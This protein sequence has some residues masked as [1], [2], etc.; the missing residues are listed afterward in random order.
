MSYV[1]RFGV[2]GLGW[3]A[4]VIRTSLLIASILHTWYFHEKTTPEMGFQRSAVWRA[5]RNVHSI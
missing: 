4:M 3:Q 1:C 5:R 2:I